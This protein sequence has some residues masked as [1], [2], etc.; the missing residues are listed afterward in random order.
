MKYIIIILSVS[1]FY[2]NA[3]FM[4]ND[5]KYG[6]NLSIIIHS[7]TEWDEEFK[8]PSE[9]DFFSLKTYYVLQNIELLTEDLL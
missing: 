9:I 7:E 1:F 6:I 5:N 8:F 4:K 3:M 2:S